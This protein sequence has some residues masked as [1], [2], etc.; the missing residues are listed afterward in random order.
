M[1]NRNS[2]IVGKIGGA[3]KMTPKAKAALKEMCASVKDEAD[4]KAELLSQLVDEAGKLLSSMGNAN[5]V[6]TEE[7]SLTDY[8]YTPLGNLIDEETQVP[9]FSGIGDGGW[10]YIVVAKV[11]AE[12]EDEITGEMMLIRTKGEI[13]EALT[14]DGWVQGEYEEEE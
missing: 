7:E 12:S 8:F 9:V 6:L 3:S 4:F 14:E 13:L 5:L 10:Q 2:K 11:S 1:A